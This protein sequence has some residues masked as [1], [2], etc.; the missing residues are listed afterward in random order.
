ME[1]V[2]AMGKLRVATDENQRPLESVIIEDCGEI[3]TSEDGKEKL[4]R[5]SAAKPFF[6]PSFATGYREATDSDDTPS[7]SSSSADEGKVDKLLISH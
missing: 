2:L 7:S 6:E 4:I 5:A 1:H 3:Q